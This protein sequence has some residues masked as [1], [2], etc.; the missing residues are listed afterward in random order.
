[1]SDSP[2][3]RAGRLRASSTATGH[4]TERSPGRRAFGSKYRKR[5]SIPYP[6]APERFKVRQ[7]S[8]PR[9]PTTATALEAQFW[10]PL[11]NAIRIQSP[12]C[13]AIRSVPNGSNRMV[14]APH[15]T[16]P[17]TSSPQPQCS[18]PPESQTAL[19]AL[20]AE[21]PSRTPAHRFL[22]LESLSFFS[23]CILPI[24]FP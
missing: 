9:F 2:I 13:A 22:G 14:A 17:A 8:C 6:H 23:R 19:V 20:Y 3:S 5:V 7:N 16:T 18:H 10:L 12:T 15:R 21:L 11:L 1:M 4:E 24:A